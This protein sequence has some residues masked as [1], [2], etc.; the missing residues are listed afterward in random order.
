MPEV[1]NRLDAAEATGMFVDDM[2]V[3]EEDD[4]VEGPDTW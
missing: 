3:A 4:V 1:G 2:A